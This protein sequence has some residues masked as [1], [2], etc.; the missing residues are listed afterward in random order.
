MSLY[1]ALVNRFVMPVIEAHKAQG[2]AEGLAE[3]REWNQRRLDA[4]AQGIPFD[5]P[6]PGGWIKGAERGRILERAKWRE[7]NQRRMDAKA[8]GRLFD[9]PPPGGWAEDEERGR[10]E[11]R[12]KWQDWNR[13]R[14]DAES[15]AGLLT[16]P[17]PPTSLT[18]NLNPTRNLPNLKGVPQCPV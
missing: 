10:T 3:W 6:Q 11:E 17:R 18:A 16:P 9:E 7:W 4:E 8:D 13:R 14:M 1:E 2:R 15:G 12:A 5:E